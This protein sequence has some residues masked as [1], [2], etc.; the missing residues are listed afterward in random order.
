MEQKQNV[1][2]QNKGQT[3]KTRE[4]MN[5]RLKMM[6]A[7]L[8]LLSGTITS[9]MTFYFRYETKNSLKILLFVMVCFYGLGLLLQNLILRFEEENRTKEEEADKEGK[10]VEKEVKKEKEA[11]P[12]TETNEG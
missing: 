4:P 6:P 7:F 11:Q 1:K 9:I 12:K 10:V 2:K 8:M 3:R 5:I